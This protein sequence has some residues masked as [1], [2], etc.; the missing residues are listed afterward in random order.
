MSERKFH[1]A[2][3]RNWGYWDGVADRERGRSAEWTKGGR[4]TRHPFDKAYGE[5]YWLGYYG[6]PHPNAKRA[7]EPKGVYEITALG[8][9]P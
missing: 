4:I 3:R 6:E 2:E 7:D 1:P 9:A 5:A 8:V